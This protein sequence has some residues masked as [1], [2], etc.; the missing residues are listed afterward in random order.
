MK[1]VITGATS[2]LGIALCR[3]V[4]AEKNEVFAVCR[5]ESGKLSALP[6]DVN[7]H[8]IYSEMSDY[9]QLNKKIE[10][11][12]VF[13]NLAWAGTGHDGR[14]NIDVQKQN[15]E[16]SIEAMK[17][18]NRM[19]CSVFVEA[20]SQAEYG[21]VL[22]EITEETPCAP[23]SEYGKAKLKVKEQGF[24]FSEKSKMKYIHLRIFSL[25]G[26]E[27]HPWTL[28]MS[29]LSKMKNNSPI[30]LSSCEQNW[31]FLHVEDGARQVYGLCL[32]A[33]SNDN[34]IHE[35]YN[36]AS[37]DT[38]PLKNFVKQMKSITDSNSMLNFGVINPPHVVSLQP[39][40][41]K[42]KAAIGLIANHDFEKDIVSIYSKI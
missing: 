5:K 2:F 23:F 31:N 20:G 1:F 8:V 33:L 34:F 13:V 25:F 3:Y 38:K 26:E 42:T 40:V 12:D 6:D 32:F 36:I 28:V 18:A 39:D 9:G 4:L 35:V 19:G 41:N 30:D 10:D 22:D 7:L 16:N 24:A 37:E 17:V 21:T 14:N 27:D 11:A 29:C 15:I